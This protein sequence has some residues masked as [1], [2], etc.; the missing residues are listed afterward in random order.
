MRN[1]WRIL[2]VMVLTVVSAVLAAPDGGRGIT[3]VPVS[4]TAPGGNAGLFVGVNQFV[5]DESLRALA[6]AVNDAI[7]Q[8]HLFVVELKLIPPANAFLALSGEP[9][10]DAAK[11]E[12][13]ALTKSGA[14]RVPATKTRVLLTLQTVA[15]LAGAE[16]DLLVVSFSSHG[17]EERAQ[18]YVMPADGARGSLR[19]T[20]LS[21]KS[22]EQKLSDSKAGKRLLLVDACREKASKESKG[23]DTVMSAAFRE[24]LA[25][26]EGKAVLTSCDTGQLSLENPELGHGVFTHFLLEALRGKAGV[27]TRGF[28]TLGT[29]SEYLEKAVPEWIKRNRPDTSRDTLQ[30]PWLAAPLSA[31]HIPLAVDPGVQTRLN[32]LRASATQAVEGL[33]P[34]INLKGAFN[35]TLYGRLA[36]ALEK[37]QDDEAGRKLLQRSQDFL[38][39]KMDEELFVAYLEKAL[40]ALAQPSQHATE[41]KPPTPTVTLPSPDSTWTNSLGMKFVPVKGTDVLFCIWETRVQDFEAFVNATGYDATQEVYTLGKD[42][43]KKRGDSW[44]S[45]GFTQTPTHPVTCVSWEDTKAF[46][47]WLTEKERRAGSLPAG[48]EYRLPTDLEWSAAVRLEGETDATPMERDR[49]V[50][51]M[52]PWGTQW[53]PPDGA[54]NYMDESWRQGPGPAQWKVLEGYNDHFTF[55]APV[56][57]F[58]PNEFGLF[59]LGGNVWEF[60][61]DPWGSAKP[62]LRVARGGCWGDDLFRGMLSSGRYP[63]PTNRRDDGTGFRM[64]LAP[65]STTGLG[66]TAPATTTETT[67][68]STPPWENSLGMKFVPVQGTD[69]QFSIWNTRVKD[70]EAFVQATG[71]DASKEMSSLGMDG[72]KKRGDT[73]QSPGFV[74]G[75]T[76][77]VCG[78]N[79]DDVKAFCKWLTEKERKEGRLR[80]DQAYRL[81][82]DAEWSV[83]VGLGVESGSTPAEKHMKIKDVYPWGTQW[84]PPRGVG[85]YAG[86]ES[87]QEAPL[88]WK[89]IDGYHDGFTRTSPVGSFTANQFGLFD[90]GGNI[91]QWCEDLYETDKERRVLRGS[92]WGASL[93]SD[94]FACLLSSYRR[95]GPSGGRSSLCGFRCVLAS[96]SAPPAASEVHPNQTSSTPAPAS[97]TLTD[98]ER[99][100]GWKLLFDGRTL[101]GW[102]VCPGTPEDAWKVEDGC[103]VTTGEPGKQLLKGGY[104]G[105]KEIFENFELTFQWKV[106]TQ[107]N[108]GVLYRV[109][110]GILFAAPEYQI[111]DNTSSTDGAIQ[112]KAAGS[113][114]NVVGPQND[115]TCPVGQFNDSRIICR[116]SHI[117]HWL[118]GVKILDCDTS[119][120]TWATATQAMAKRYSGFGTSTRGRIFLQ[121]LYPTASFRN[122]K[123][124]TF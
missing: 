51:G 13:A 21:L 76:H 49:K 62:N 109:G 87:K 43:W 38:G 114:W 72:W 23:G 18:A 118:N 8:A 94:A 52:Y 86:E 5:E 19:D 4:A 101:D 35:L 119:S 16:T 54:G 7:A 105:T 83:A 29:V 106:S 80:V 102:E 112:S 58:R 68:A 124:R 63:F 50:P 60:C 55:T 89:A 30:K 85:N 14:Q 39:S 115:V 45:P 56:G 66:L 46:C 59:D 74:Q 34:K 116:G 120:D 79:W 77:P 103:I 84:P 81:P 22:V 100:A 91:W 111:L 53:P 47:K 64:V 32:A 11:A 75:P 93:G 44:K 40:P 82:T 104:L 31:R 41:T 98:A 10:T 9:T 27:D 25:G 67:P 73:W 61:E 121:N 36:D 37:A 2:M 24:A 57:S 15:N 71:Y 97:N 110:P 95:S 92:S 117:E 99:V 20:A 42:G 122:I 78:V 1:Q 26:A 33:K 90:M 6:F 3:V 28:I 96:S 108:S 48:K 107:A 65:S 88:S 113:I 17:F 70:F 123:I 69:V 12:L